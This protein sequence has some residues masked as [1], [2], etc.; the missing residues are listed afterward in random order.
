MN[1]KLSVRILNE[2]FNIARVV[3]I[4]N[5]QIAIEIFPFFYVIQ[6]F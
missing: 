2:N 3:K 6:Q 5:K 1:R 4:K